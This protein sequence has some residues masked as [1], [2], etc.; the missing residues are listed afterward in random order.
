[1]K[2]AD[3]CLQLAPHSLPLVWPPPHLVTGPR[4]TLSASQPLAGL[5]PQMPN[6]LPGQLSSGLFPPPCPSSHSPHS[7]VSLDVT[8]VT[9]L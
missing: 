1:M 9:L 7:S 5:E 8:L 2:Q 6:L 4:V 3:V